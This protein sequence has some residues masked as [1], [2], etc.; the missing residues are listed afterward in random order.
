MAMQFLHST[1]FHNA[2]AAV[3]NYRTSHDGWD[4]DPG[5]FT[6]AFGNVPYGQEAG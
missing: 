4:H 1:Y 6:G 3:F 2:D 5:G